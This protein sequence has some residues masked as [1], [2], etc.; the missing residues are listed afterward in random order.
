M[1]A[2]T[3]INSGGLRNKLEARLRESP[4]G[5]DVTPKYGPPTYGLIGDGLEKCAEAQLIRI[6]A[7]Y[8]L[9]GLQT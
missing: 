6:A 3:F 7:L 2:L 8:E 5:I 9:A 4:N 1:M